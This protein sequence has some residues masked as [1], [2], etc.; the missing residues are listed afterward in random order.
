MAQSELS[1]T[2]TDNEFFR[3]CCKGDYENTARLLPNI[4]SNIVVDVGLTNACSRGDFQL[5]NLLIDRA[6]MFGVAFTALKHHEFG[7]KNYKEYMKFAELL[8]QRGLTEYLNL[9]LFQICAGSFKNHATLLVQYGADNFNEVLSASC[10]HG[11]VKT[12]EYMIEC[13]A[14]NFEES[15]RRCYLDLMS[16]PYNQTCTDKCLLLLRK[17]LKPLF[18]EFNGIVYLLLEHGANLEMFVS[19]KST[20]LLGT[21]IQEFRKT[22]QE[23]FHVLPNVL[24]MLVSDYSLA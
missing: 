22:I 17:S 20:E 18:C 4:Q 9:Y 19:T 2:D 5:A 10:F 16:D 15:F 23:Q 21:T 3:Y 12:M 6:Q 8:I 7:D 13:G 1:F 11:D 24:L 14:N